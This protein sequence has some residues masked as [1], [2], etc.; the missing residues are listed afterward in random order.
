MASGGAV[1][2]KN[3]EIFPLRL[4][5]Y[6][7]HEAQQ[8]LPSVFEFD[9]SKATPDRSQPLAD[10][11]L[12]R[13][14]F[15]T[16]WTGKQR[17]ADVFA[18][19]SEM[20]AYSFDDPEVQREFQ[21]G[22]IS[23]SVQVVFNAYATTYTDLAQECRS[24]IG[25]C[26]LPL[27]SIEKMIA[28]DRLE[29]GLTMT[30]NTKN[31]TSS[32]DVRTCRR[33]D[34]PL[35]KGVIFIEQ[36][37]MFDPATNTVLA[38]DQ[39]LLKLRDKILAKHALIDIT[40]DTERDRMA[41]DMK[42]IIDREMA[43]FFSSRGTLQNPTVESL[44]PFHTPELRTWCTFGP[45]IMYL[46]L[47][48]RAKSTK[49]F[50][51]NLI[52]T[53]R[54]RRDV[55]SERI[56]E[57]ARFYFKKGSLTAYAYAFV[58]F[59]GAVVALL[60]ISLAYLDDV[61]NENVAGQPWDP[62]KVTGTEDNKI[63]SIEGADDCDGVARENYAQAMDII[64]NGEDVF[65]ENVPFSRSQDP[66]IE[67]FR[68][69]RRL[70][71]LYVPVLMLGA[72]TTDKLVYDAPLLANTQT[73]AIAHTFCAM[74]PFTL[75]MQL[76]GTREATELKATNAFRDRAQEIERS[77]KLGMDLPVQI[78]EGT[79]NSDSVML[80]VNVFYKKH[81]GGEVMAEA[82]KQ[83]AFRVI[84]QRSELTGPIHAIIDNTRLQTEMFIVEHMSPAI[85]AN[86]RSVST[87]YQLCGGFSTTMFAEQRKFNWAFTYTGVNGRPTYGIPFNDLVIP[88]NRLTGIATSIRSAVGLEKVL[89]LSKL[90]AA[91]CDMII[92]L[93]EPAPSFDASDEPDL[94][95]PIAAGVKEL[96][97][98][99]AISWDDAGRLTGS[100]RGTPIHRP[101]IPITGR[102]KDIG[103]KEAEALQKVA[104]M[105]AWSVINVRWRRVAKL[106][107]PGTDPIDILDVDFFF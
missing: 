102:V 90:E 64:C 28:D 95:V 18:P 106:D 97:D 65:P 63:A 98:N 1:N 68:N 30:Q 24:R 43:V 48:S 88:S 20:G 53:V 31:T 40:N 92:A 101:I 61:Q 44:R 69:I 84:A 55:S 6:A 54:A 26:G 27:S 78:I 94:S 91:K 39:A 16:P 38:K 14:I 66:D 83:R 13:F 57:W 103:V 45:S 105:H 77:E 62:K 79:A 4:H 33:T 89:V 58:S 104:K 3:A 99:L 37:S 76:V 80:P 71:R 46:C 51:L 32:P 19:M 82:Q 12:F 17:V 50:Y 21:P 25:S 81:D 41:R 87:F 74:L 85:E 60:A 5:V 107:I 100:A 15:E 70:L 93:E 56:N 42:A 23:A 75:F 36:V 29:F 9:N 35:V 96:I 34:K 7:T 67:T 49:E 11:R 10:E 52:R 47:H 8:P 22:K 59:C 2:V 72:V 86:T 73:P